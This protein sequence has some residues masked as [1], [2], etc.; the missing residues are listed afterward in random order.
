M[1]RAPSLEQYRLF[2]VN[3]QAGAALQD[4]TLAIAKK[5]GAT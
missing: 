4:L 5:A 1:S 3:V 2:Y